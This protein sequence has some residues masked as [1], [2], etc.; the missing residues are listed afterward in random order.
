M[1]FFDTYKYELLYGIKYALVINFSFS[2]MIMVY[3]IFLI[4]KDTNDPKESQK[5][6]LMMTVAG[7]IELV[8]KSTSAYFGWTKKRKRGITLGFIMLGTAVS[9]L[10]LLQ[11]LD[12]WD[13]LK[14]SPI[15]IFPIT[16]VF[17]SAP[18]LAS[19]AEK[20]P[21]S[22]VGVV[23]GFSTIVMFGLDFIFPLLDVKSDQNARIYKFTAGFGMIILFGAIVNNL[24]T[25]ECGGMSR[26]Q[27]RKRF[28]RM[29]R[30]EID[31][32]K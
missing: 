30:E 4:C 1:A 31:E 10:A 6:N 26:A 23:Q 19:F 25:F 17:I 14:F 13:L 9:G 7:F 21:Q 28:Q 24:V 8:M 15:V 2:S 20:F 12:R 22:V 32:A 3:L 18:Y 11:Y 5:A 27:I 16:G 29:R